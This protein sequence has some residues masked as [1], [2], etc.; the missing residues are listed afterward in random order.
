MFL[1]SSCQKFHLQFLFEIFLVWFD[2]VFKAVVTVV[3]GPGIGASSMAKK[4]A[5]LVVCLCV[6]GVALLVILLFI[7]EEESVDLFL[8][9]HWLFDC[10][11]SLLLDLTVA[12]VRS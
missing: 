3:L 1:V 8:L 7:T 5:L 2:I 11:S 9:E 10:W 4:L 6:P 12:V